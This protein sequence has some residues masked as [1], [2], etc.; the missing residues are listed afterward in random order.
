MKECFPSSKFA[1][2]IAKATEITSSRVL[3]R[4]KG[5]GLKGREEDFSSQ[6]AG[7]ITDHLI[8][9]I[10]AEVGQLSNEKVKF[11]CLV[12]KKKTEKVVGADLAGSISYPSQRGSNPK[13]YL[14]QAKIGSIKGSKYS[15]A[16]NIRAGDKNL[17]KQCKDM[18]AITPASFVFVYSEA[19]VHVVPAS[20]V[21]TKGEGIVNTEIDYYKGLD[22]FYE[23]V[24]KCFIGDMSIGGFYR[25]EA[26]LKEYAENIAAKRFLHIGIR[27]MDERLVEHR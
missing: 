2:A 1:A 10:A 18:L 20:A 15:S 3:N 11:D 21:V 14:A 5:R 16:L 24:Y 4:Y 7:E 9:Q 25:D 13:V 19:G 23:E 8:D 12:Y 27:K 22:A 26:R 17:L 6:L